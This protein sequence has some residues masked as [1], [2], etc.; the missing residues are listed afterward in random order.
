MRAMKDSG[1]EWIG[2]IPEGWEVTTVKRKYHF[3]VGWTP[4]TSRSELFDG[5]NIW[6]N[7]SDMKSKRVI[8]AAKRLSD[9]AIAMA[10][11]TPSP[12]GS[13]LFA[14]K[15]SVGAVAFC[16]TD[17]YTNE[18]IA[19]FLPGDESLDYLFYI[20][21]VFIIMNANENIYGAK[22]LNQQLIRNAKIVLPPEST[23]RKI[24]SFLDTKCAQIDAIIE[25]QQQVIEMLKA[26]KQS[27]I[28]E[29]VTKGLDPTVP[30]KD[31][32]VEWIGMVPEHWLIEQSK[33]A[34][35]GIFDINHYMP[36]S[37][38]SGIPYL[39]TG[40]LATSTSLVDF[41]NCKQISIDDYQLL[42]EKS[43]PMMGDVI[44]ARYATI[45]T[46]CY[47]D[48]T[49]QF[50]V[51]YSCV[52]IRSDKQ[53]LLGKY[54]FYY[55][56]STAFIEEVK[57]FINSNTQNNIGIDS[58]SKSRIILPPLNEQVHLVSCIVKAC[59]QIDQAI[60]SKQSIIQKLISYKKSLIYEAVTGKMEV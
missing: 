12:K 26:Y 21:P 10:R 13:L 45:G 38:D 58:L 33:Y 29:A 54:L 36:D 39:M 7:I 20:A 23:Q 17:M 43:C 11:I 46:V 22:L 30:M 4:D 37:V 24:V 6:V 14:F 1:V 53:I 40:D 48:T 9:E 35:Q 5:A 49:T 51:S 15:L 44:F 42:S 52:T 57:R 2:E 18:A 19:T 59:K 28:T 8:D 3:Q 27:V 34:Y 50:L 60:E 32:G 41:E 16:D 47:V 31:S 56:Q 55:L 25:K